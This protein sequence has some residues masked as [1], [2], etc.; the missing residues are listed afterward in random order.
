MYFFIG[1]GTDSQCISNCTYIYIYTHR[2]RNKPKQPQTV[3]TNGD[4]YEP[5]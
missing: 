5:V 4:K 2:G 3:E 1:K